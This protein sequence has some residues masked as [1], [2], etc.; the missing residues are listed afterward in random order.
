VLN[1][2][3]RN[4][5]RCPRDAKAVAFK[6]LVRPKLEYTACSWDFYTTQQI[7]SLE[8]VQ[9]R[10]ARFVKHD[11]RRTSSVTSM[12]SQLGWESLQSRRKVSWLSLFAKA[13]RGAV[14]ILL[15]G[16]VRQN[17][18][19]RRTGSDEALTFQQIS[20]H[21]DTF[22]YSFISRTVVGWCQL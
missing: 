6:T 21:C 13:M 20:T 3:R 9:R 5:S 22:Q 18:S 1:F 17:R 7:Y 15:G 4:I 19:T 16:V 2:L 11:C 10:A 8:M 12:M 14:A